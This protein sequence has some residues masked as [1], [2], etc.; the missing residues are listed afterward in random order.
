MEA[1]VASDDPGAGKFDLYVALH[2]TFSISSNSKNIVSFLLMCLLYSCYYSRHPV[3]YFCKF[4]MSKFNI[5]KISKF[6]S[7]FVIS[8]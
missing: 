8:M 4:D 3:A 6:T 1:E 7:N 5:S 2:C